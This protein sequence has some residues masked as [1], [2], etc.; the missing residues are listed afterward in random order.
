MAKIQKDLAYKNIVL[1]HHLLKK[2]QD[3]EYVSKDV[4][5]DLSKLISEQ[6]EDLVAMSE[7]TEDEI[8]G[9]Y[10]AI[11]SGGIYSIEL[12]SNL[13]EYLEKV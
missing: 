4:V 8:D 10:A 1:L 7:L 6:T 13:E 12:G 9:I 11:Q 5:W 2:A 3:E